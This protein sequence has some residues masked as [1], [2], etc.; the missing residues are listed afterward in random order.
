MK[1]VGHGCTCGWCLKVEGK[2]MDLPD[3]HVSESDS[4]G[5]DDEDRGVY[6]HEVSTKRKDK[7]IPL[8][9]PEAHPVTIQGECVVGKELKIADKSSFLREFP[10]TRI[11]WYLGAEIND[12]DY[13]LPH[14]S[15]EGG[16]STHFVVPPDAVGRFILAKV[17]RNVED[18]VRHR[19]P[20]G[21][22]G[23]EGTTGMVREGGGGGAGVEG[24]SAEVLAL[25]VHV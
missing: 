14:C 2:I 20:Q 19:N 18:Q 25:Y 4:S 5:S 22:E 9:D 24:S 1:S 6:H 3:Y 8:T 17:Y 11:E 13:F 15:K 23:W 10:I 16:S 21:S 12:H 7:S